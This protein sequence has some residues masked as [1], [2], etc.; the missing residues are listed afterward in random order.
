[1]EVCGSN[2]SDVAI[3]GEAYNFFSQFLFLVYIIDIID[4]HPAKAK[5]KKM[6]RDTYKRKKIQ[7]KQL[8]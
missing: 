3:F 1:M 4:C 6:G 5:I 8:N 7:S 2:K